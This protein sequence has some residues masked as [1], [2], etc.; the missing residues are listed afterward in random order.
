MKKTKQ[1]KKTEQDTMWK[2]IVELYLREFLQFF[3]PDI[4]KDI[5]F[6]KKYEFLDKELK[7]IMKASER[8]WNCSIKSI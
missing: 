3:F 5:D 6:S 1:K 4:Y 7:K 8:G 2:E